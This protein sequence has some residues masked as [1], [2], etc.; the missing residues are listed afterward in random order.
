[1]T[2]KYSSKWEVEGAVD[3]CVGA[4]R[5]IHEIG[6]L[7]HHLLTL[8]TRRK[9]RETKMKMKIEAN[10]TTNTNANTNNNNTPN[11]SPNGVLDT[12]ANPYYYQDMLANGT[13]GYH[14]A[15]KGWSLYYSID[16]YP[17][18]YHGQSEEWCWASPNP[19]PNG[20]GNSGNSGRVG[21]CDVGTN[22]TNTNTTNTAIATATDVNNKPL[23]NPTNATTT[24]NTSPSSPSA[25]VFIPNKDTWKNCIFINCEDGKV[26]PW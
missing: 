11:T 23:S 22:T 17:Y 21:T 3:S 10:T 16:G 19:N 15:W 18:Y 26:I 12:N 20:G 25:T 4:K 9:A 14:T 6:Q 24:T 1:M 13:G 8:N 7:D 2:S 5:V